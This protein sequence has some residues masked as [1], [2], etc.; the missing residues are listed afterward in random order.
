MSTFPGLSF[1]KKTFIND[2]IFKKCKFINDVIFIKGINSNFLKLF[3]C[4][5]NL[6]ICGEIVKFELRKIRM[7][8]FCRVKFGKNRKSKVE[9]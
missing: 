7:D 1:N 5:L 2:G 3:V 9:I 6:K 4:G 8:L